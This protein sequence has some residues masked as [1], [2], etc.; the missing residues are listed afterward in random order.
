MSYW[1]RDYVYIPLGG[2]RK[3]LARQLFNIMV[4][5]L[6]TG[7]W[8]GASWNFVL[9][10]IF[11]GI[12]LIIEKLFL[13][14]VLKKAPD[15]VCHVYTMVIVM[16][17]WALFANTDISRALAY[18]GMMFGH[19]SSFVNAA[20]LYYLRDNLFLIVVCIIACTPVANTKLNFLNQKT[21]AWSKPVLV[22]LMMLICTAFIVDGTYNPFLYFRF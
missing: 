7:F 3:G 13:L 10:G 6:L 15:W 12:V 22:L 2:N 11:Y 9:W 17:A 20:S 5:W 21:F 1:F 8:H 4:V 19:A 16:V 18:I 14:R